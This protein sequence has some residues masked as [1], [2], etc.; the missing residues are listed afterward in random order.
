MIVK[1][2]DI[3]KRRMEGVK[4]TLPTALLMDGSL[5]WLLPRVCPFFL[6]T[7]SSM[8]LMDTYLMQLV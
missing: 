6:H 5:D 7:C 4:M 3:W 2:L 8:N 1:K